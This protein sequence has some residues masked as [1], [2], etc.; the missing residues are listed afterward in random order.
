[1]FSSLRTV[2]NSV[3]IFRGWFDQCIFV[4][5]SVDIWSVDQLFSI[6]VGSFRRLFGRYFM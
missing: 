5:M 3:A 1:M 4:G 6:S 2:I